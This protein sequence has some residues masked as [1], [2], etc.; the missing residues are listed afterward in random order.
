MQMLEEFKT[1]CYKDIRNDFLP[2]KPGEKPLSVTI[3]YKWF[4]IV[5][6]V[7]KHFARQMLRL[8][9]DQGLI[10]FRGHQKILFKENAY[11]TV[12]QPRAAKKSYPQR[13]TGTLI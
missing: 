4:S 12:Q 13:R 6:N 3:A 11:A 5:C 2:F 8:W 1:F 7:D 10:E 9:K